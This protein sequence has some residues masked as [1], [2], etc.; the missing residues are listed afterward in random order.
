MYPPLPFSRFPAKNVISCPPIRFTGAAVSHVPAAFTLAVVVAEQPTPPCVTVTP[1]IDPFAFT[2]RRRL[3]RATPAERH[4]HARPIRIPSQSVLAAHRHRRH[5]AARRRHRQRRLHRIPRRHHHRIPHRPSLRVAAQIQHQPRRRLARRR[6]ISR[7]RHH[8]IQHVVRSRCRRKR[9]R[10]LDRHV[11][12]AIRIRIQSRRR[13]HRQRRNRNARIQSANIDVPELAPLR[14]LRQVQ[15]ARMRRMRSRILRRHRIHARRRNL[16]VLNLR[17]AQ[18][19]SS[20]ARR[21]RHRNRAIAHPPRRARSRRS[22]QPIS[23]RRKNRIRSPSAGSAGSFPPPRAPRPASTTHPRSGPHKSSDRAAACSSACSARPV[24][25]PAHPAPGN[26]ISAETCLP[27]PPIDS[28]CQLS[29]RVL[30]VPSG[31]VSATPCALA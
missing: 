24:R 29:V 28:P 2:A 7:H 1:A 12:P 16:H 14:P 25:S 11:L 9:V 19:V 22:R 3:R 23:A 20:R 6:G 26:P 31:I 18:P 30:H 5:R 10:R 8:V 4:R 15:S 21:R 13:R 17:H 27:N